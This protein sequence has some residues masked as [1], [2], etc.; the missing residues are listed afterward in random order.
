D[1]EKLARQKEIEDWLPI[2]S[3]RNAK[4]WYS[5]FHNVTAMCRSSRP[6]LRHV[7]ARLVKISIIL[8]TNL[9]RIHQKIKP[10]LIGFSKGPGVAVLVLSWVITLYTLWQ[11]VEMHEWFRESVLIVTMNSDNTRLEKSLLIVEIG[12]CIVYMVT[13]GKSLKKFHELVC[14]DCKP[15]KLTY[16]VG[17]NVQ[18]DPRLLGR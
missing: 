17:L 10:V 15:I 14:E 11:L 7:S 16:F 8:A 5:A 3:S 6:P 4:W 2:T 1:D 9:N 13:G 12:V 18:T